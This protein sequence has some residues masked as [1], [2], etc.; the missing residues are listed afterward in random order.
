MLAG[1]RRLGP[2]LEIGGNGALKIGGYAAGGRDALLRE[3][4]DEID[5]S[6]RD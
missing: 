1:A 2:G 6:A 4:G 5:P 3:L